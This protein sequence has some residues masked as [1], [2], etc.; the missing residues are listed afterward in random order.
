MLLIFNFFA[1]GLYWLLEVYLLDGSVAYYLDDFIVIISCSPGAA[2]S[3][4][5][6]FDAVFAY[7]TNRLGIPYNRSK[8]VAGTTV[9]VLGIEIDTISL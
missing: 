6:R 1:E 8:D 2:C 4:L 7:L 5:A 3:F 9:T